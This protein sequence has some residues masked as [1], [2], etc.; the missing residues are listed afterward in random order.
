M[1]KILILG[2][3]GM[4][5]HMIYTHLKDLQKYQIIGTV[6]S[7]SFDGITRK[8]NIFDRDDVQKLIEEIKPDII[9]NCIGM[10][11]KGSK[12]SP[13]NA[14]F[15]NAFFP[16]FLK[17]IA[18]QNNSTLIHI[19]TDC[20]FSGKDGCYKELSFKDATDIYGLS[21][22][23]GEIVD[24]KNLTIRTSIIGPELKQNGEGL[25]HWFMSQK[26]QVNGYKSN[27][28]SG[29]TTLELAKFIEWTLDNPL[30]GLVHLTNNMPISKFDLLN[31]F[32]DVYNKKLTI[33]AERDYVCDKSFINTNEINYKVP[34]YMM[35][36][37]DQKNFMEK[38]RGFYDSYFN[39]TI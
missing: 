36:L 16:H 3:A 31:V 12:D 30:T 35:M 26:N 21:K 34:T 11:I 18:S 38:Y 8:L 1:K 28:W 2:A 32:N 19:S 9:I 20:V 37:Q 4:A 23:L 22:S 17:K 13:E 33:V 7:N 25:F 10:L 5:G 6:N 24:E 29:V 15:A 27:F 39:G 14:I